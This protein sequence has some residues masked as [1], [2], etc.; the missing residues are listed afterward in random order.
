ML[1]SMNTAPLW[2][3]VV[4]VAACS[5]SASKS[6]SSPSG[7]TAFGAGDTGEAFLSRRY[8]PPSQPLVDCPGGV[9]A[10]L[11]PEWHSMKQD[12]RISPAEVYVQFDA[13]AITCRVGIGT[14]PRFCKK[15]DGW[16]T[17]CT[18]RDGSRP[19]I[20]QLRCTPSTL[21]VW[22]VAPE[23]EFRIAEL[24]RPAGAT[25]CNGT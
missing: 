1:V 13:E 11:A 7:G 17:T 23:G 24:P 12:D 16:S 3:M 19:H 4:V 18:N 15:T 5:S 25:P 22:V 9:P 6:S 14:F 20:G 21:E 10:K 8:A 2:A